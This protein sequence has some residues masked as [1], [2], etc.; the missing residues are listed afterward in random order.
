[1]I[2]LIGNSNY[3]FYICSIKLVIKSSLKNSLKQLQNIDVHGCKTMKIMLSLKR[4]LTD[5]NFSTILV[6]R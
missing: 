4:Y 1:M 5:N 3:H 6:I 2:V